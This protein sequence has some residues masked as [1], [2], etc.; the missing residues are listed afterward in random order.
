MQDIKKQLMAMMILLKCFMCLK[1]VQ[2]FLYS[3]VQV[4]KAMRNELCVLSIFNHDP[5]HT[6][7]LLKTD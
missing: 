3:S 6:G 4:G 1:S 2:V 5:P 7:S